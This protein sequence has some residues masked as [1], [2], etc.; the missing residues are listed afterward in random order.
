MT[1]GQPLGRLI[2]VPISDVW[3]DEASQFTPWLARSENMALLAEELGLGEMEVD[4]VEKRIGNFFAD[5]VARDNRGGLVLVENQL[6]TSDHL[7]LGQILTYLAGL[8]GEATVIWIT[9]RF[10]EEHRAA[11]DWLNANT[12]D[13][14]DFFG[15]EIELFRIGQSSPAP[16]FNIVAK[17]NHWS[18]TNRRIAEAAL[19]EGDRLYLDY[20][21]SYRDFWAARDPNARLSVPRAGHV[22]RIPIR[23][24]F[25]LNAVISRSERWMRVEIYIQIKGEAPKI[26][27]RA[28]M[29]D[30]VAIEGELRY[31]LSWNEVPDRQATRIA[32][33]KRDV[34]IANPTSWDE[35]HDWM[36]EK[37][38]EFKRVLEPRIRALP[39]SIY[40]GAA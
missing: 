3:K 37:M 4:A 35:Q 29:N 34:D 6:G 22:Y 26:A 32:V 7:H 30:K 23:T 38:I 19:N 40:E 10:R 1:D 36:L 2:T 11:V 17:P 8:E 18:R 14:F 9:T 28:L 21:T 16:R 27:L 12:N 33:S 39:S 25:A 5:I 20:W 15:I 24:G 13:Q 31:D